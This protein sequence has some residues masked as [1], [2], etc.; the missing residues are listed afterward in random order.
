MID[1][2]SLAVRDLA[3]SARFYEA[4]LATLGHARLVERP[5]TVGFGK[6]YAELW[7]N[8]REDTAHV[9]AGSGAHVCLRARSAEAVQ[10]FHRIALLQGGTDDGPPGPRPD[11]N[12][13]QVYYA[14]FVRDLDGNRLEAVCFLP[15]E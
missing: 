9:A 10:A 3:A 15:K 1:H 2:I 13:D 7:L 12:P 4:V 6:R 11:D 8:L 14:A 5:R